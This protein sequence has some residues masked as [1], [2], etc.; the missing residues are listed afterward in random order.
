VRIP[1]R[2]LREFVDTAAEPRDAAERLTMAGIETG[3]VAESAAELG[4]L[5]VAE[6]LA[7]D[8]HPAGGALRVCEVSTGG[9]RY[10]VVCGAPNVRAGVRAAFAPPGAALPGGRRVAVAT[11]RGTVSEGMLCSEAELGVGDDAS[12]LLLLGADAP[13]GADLVSHLGIDDAIL[14]V[15]VT[16]NRPDCL[17]IVGVARELAALTGGRLR[18]PDSTVREDPALTT[19]GWR[20]TIE[21]PDLCPRYAAR[22]STDVA[23]GPSPAWLAQRLRAAGLRPINNV[24]DVTN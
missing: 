3:L 1:Y 6:V 18:P 7:V 12:G 24:V 19:A 21:D 15:E 2:W 5:V 16:P 17:A 22:L 13:V 14:E 10:R 23:V 11:I 4:G 9:E 8:A 20:I